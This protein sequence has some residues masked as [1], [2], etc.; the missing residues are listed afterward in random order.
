MKKFIIAGLS[1]AMV[2]CQTIKDGVNA[3]LDAAVAPVNGGF[4]LLDMLF[5]FLKN[6]FGAA[7]NTIFH[8]FLPF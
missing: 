4:D 1:L 6:V 2:G 5:G 3:G 8:G 7:L